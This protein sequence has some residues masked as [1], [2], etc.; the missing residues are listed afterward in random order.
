[1]YLVVCDAVLVIIIIIIIIIM[2]TYS[3]LCRLCHSFD[4]TVFHILSSCPVLA[5]TGYLQWHNSVAALI[6]KHICEY[7][8]IPTC[9]KP[10][11]YSPQAVV[12]FNHIKILWDVDI[13]T[14][15]IIS[16]H[17]PDIVI[18]DSLERSAILIDASRC[19]HH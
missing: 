15:R 9:E 18:H 6:H 12:T 19:E 2:V 16:A 14:D 7:Y 11:L 4:E 10:W 5:P 3:R 1:M 13:R 8:G 17:R